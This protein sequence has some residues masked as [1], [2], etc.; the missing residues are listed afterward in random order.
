MAETPEELATYATLPTITGR[1]FIPWSSRAYAQEL[2]SGTSMGETSFVTPVLKP[3]FLKT[4]QSDAATV[5][6]SNKMNR[7]TEIT[8]KNLLF[9]FLFISFSL[10]YSTIKI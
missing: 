8:G 6:E 2:E 4:G 1:L 5:E 7:K 10:P 9:V 3:S